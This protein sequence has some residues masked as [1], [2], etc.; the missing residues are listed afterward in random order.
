MKWKNKQTTTTLIKQLIKFRPFFSG[1]FF[2]WFYKLLVCPAYRQKIKLIPPCNEMIKKSK[3]YGINLQLKQIKVHMHTKWYKKKNAYKHL[4]LM[5]NFTLMKI[6][7]N[8]CI[9]PSLFNITGIILWMDILK[10][11][12]CGSCW[13]YYHLS[14]LSLLHY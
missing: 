6:V 1:V 5:L 4:L 7:T 12:V 8:C 9:Y 10:S 14:C 13:F 3:S 2:S 11:S